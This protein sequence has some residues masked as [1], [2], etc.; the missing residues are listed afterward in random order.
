MD[1]GGNFAGVLFWRWA[2][3]GAGGDLSEL[4]RSASIHTDTPAF[5]NVVRPYGDYVKSK[6]CTP[7]GS[8]GRKAVAPANNASVAVASA[9]G[10]GGNRRL[11]ASD[12]R[13]L[14]GSG[15][16]PDFFKVPTPE[17]AGA[18]CNAAYGRLD[19]G[20]VTKTVT[21]KSVADCCAAAKAASA[22]AW[23][24]CY[25]DAGCKDA[26]G[27]AVAKGGCQLRSVPHPYYAPTQ[28]M[29][30]GVGWISGAPGAV[31]VLPAF[32]CQLKGAGG[33]GADADPATCSPADLKKSVVCADDAC[34]AEQKNVDGNLI[35]FDINSATPQ[36][37]ILT[38]A[39]CCAACRAD[40]TCTA[41]TFCPL[42]EGCAKDCKTYVASAAPGKGFG[43]HGSCQGD[44]FPYRA[45][46]LK[47]M[48]DGKHTVTA[49]GP[50]QPWV[51]GVIREKGA[52]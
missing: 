39:D 40:A 30:D 43:P 27:A 34:R 35:V 38:A 51:S 32:K 2:A 48:P 1:G 4:D 33:C 52:A 29:G 16:G 15:P 10:G 45:C 21:A 46:S 11:A 25:C 9:S 23:S 18:S 12:T 22:T 3:L 5:A 26:A 31:S 17:D 8:G 13:R 14:Q 24:Y 28:A 47:A 41:W 36:P 42:K 19:A 20:E 7:S 49:S 37:T 6:K 50:H 44:A